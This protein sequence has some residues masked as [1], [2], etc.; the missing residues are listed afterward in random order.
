MKEIR[1]TQNKVALIDDEDFGRVNKY[2]W[3]LGANGRYV[4]TSKG[5]YLHRFIMDCPKKMYVDHIDHN[6]LNNQKVN[7]RLCTQQQNCFNQSKQ[8]RANSS[9]YKGV[10]W[11]KN[12]NKW[13]A[14]I[15]IN[16]KKIHIGLFEIERHAA[17]AYDIWAKELFGKFARL[18]F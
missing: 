2:N 18:N 13:L 17:M 7:L 6:G 12:N 11:V 9:I 15:K 4:M 14:K 8:K 16:Q 5:L 3:F 10:S 1:L